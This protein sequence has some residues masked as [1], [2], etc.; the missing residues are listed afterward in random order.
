VALTSGPDGLPRFSP[1][2]TQVLFIRFAGPKSD[3]YRVP[4]VGGEPRK[5]LDDVAVADWSPDG[6]EIVFVRRR[7]EG[8][9]WVS[10]IGIV[11]ASGEGERE[12]ARE[13]NLTI[14]APRWS[15][16]GGTIALINRGAE[17]T[18]STILLVHP[19][20]TGRRVLE[21][22]PPAGALTPVVW[23]GDG[24][25]IVYGKE[26]G[27]LSAGS[28][29]GSGRILRQE[30][31]SGRSQ[32][33]LWS[34][35]RP[36]DVAILAPGSLILG[37]NTQRVN[38]LVSGAASGAASGPGRLHR[39]ITRGNAIDRQPV[40]SPDGEWVMFSSNRSGN[41]ELWKVSIATGAIRRLTDDPAQ[42]WDPAFTPEGHGILWSSSRTGH[43]EIWAG[44]ADGTG[45]RR[46]T[47]DGVDAE[48]PTM[49]PDGQWV[50]YNSSNPDKSGIWKIRADGTQA[51][52]LVP[53]FWS[54]PEVSPDGR[55]VAFR[56]RAV[57]RVLRIARLSDGLLERVAIGSDSG[58]N[59][60]AR[61]RWLSGGREIL[62]NDT[63]QDGNGGIFAQ[64]FVP[65]T[66]TARTRRLLAGLDT[67]QPIDSFAMSPDG[68]H[69]VQAIADSLD[70]LLL[71]EGVPGIEP[72]RPTRGP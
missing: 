13:E 19:D 4:V 54:T 8:E 62:F 6:R 23:S 64:A 30:I 38:L 25:V 42:D 16:D 60:N 67:G 72:P 21:T 14:V 63:D 24:R 47:D 66:D 46:L 26:E 11:G 36:V 69:L 3:L 9:K 35:T 57:P 44:N 17:N 33:V 71:A 43:F 53:G 15:P 48:N 70:S 49:T 55:W 58:F 50:V 34:P 29:G 20:G 65:G 56:T 61:P 28:L 12:I 7:L 45:A 2:G 51:T 41:L 52:R 22:P 39:W 5:I 59:N 32:V 27:F 40:F 37:G 10:G 68:T 31:G 18:P 1:D